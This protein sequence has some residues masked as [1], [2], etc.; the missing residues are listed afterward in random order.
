MAQVSRRS[1]RGIKK[2]SLGERPR[3]YKEIN[4]YQQPPE[5]ESILL[6]QAAAQDG[7]IRGK[8]VAA[9]NK[10][11]RKARDQPIGG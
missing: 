11:N 5:C 2:V 4:P 6:C 8:P 10:I 9:L 7:K 1:A 3:Y